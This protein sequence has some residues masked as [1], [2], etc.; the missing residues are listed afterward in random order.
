M[1]IVPLT[2]SPSSTLQ[3]VLAGQNCSIALRTLDGYATSDSVDLSVG[4]PYIAFTLDV[5]GVSITRFQSCLNLKRLLINRQYLGFIGDFIF[6]D[7]QPDP[8]TGPADPQWA[9]LG[10]RWQLIYLEASDLT[11][12]VPPINVS[13][14]PGPGPALPPPVNPG[15]PP[16]TDYVLVAGANSSA[17]GFNVSP[18]YGSLTPNTFGSNVITSLSWDNVTSNTLLTLTINAVLAQAVFTTL[19]IPDGDFGSIDLNSSSAT[20]TSGG[21]IS[22]WIWN[23]SNPFTNAGTYHPQI[24]V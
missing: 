15:P 20:F 12:E 5:S 3:I 18:A 23:V 17:V 2:P 21:G 1:Q 11:A 4:Q 19:A 16:E 6:V 13:G 8:V 9:G 10:D 14:R 7:T 24:L 22:T